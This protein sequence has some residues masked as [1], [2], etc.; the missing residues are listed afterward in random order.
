MAIKVP[1]RTVYDNSNNAIG[2]SEFQSGDAVGY[3][4][5]GTGLITLGT[6]NQVLKVND[7]GTAIEWANEDALA[8]TGVATGTFGSASLIPIITVGADGRIT[9]IS[10]TAVAGVANF[11]WTSANST[12]RI[13]TSA[14]TNFDAVINNFNNLASTGVPT[15]TFGSASQ[16]PVITVGADGRITNISNTAVAGVQSVTYNTSNSLLTI[17]TSDG[18]SQT[19]NITLEPF[20]TDD[21][22]EGGTN[23]YFTTARAR[24]SFTAGS[25]INITSGV[26]SQATEIDYG[27]IT[28]A[29]GANTIDY[30]SIG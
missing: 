17:N 29:V 24:S 2:L 4:H 25:G 11:T 23:L 15:G 20:D 16:V 21:L 13:S 8:A 10:N 14:G 9:N 12:L 5:G 19:T 18:G 1:I 26:I 27:L 6:A 30:G 3:Q 28:G 22:V 7:A